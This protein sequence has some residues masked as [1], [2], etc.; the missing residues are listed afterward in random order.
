MELEEPEPP[1]RF[2][3]LIGKLSKKY[4]GQKEA[5]LIDEYDT[6]ILDEIAKPD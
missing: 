5:V 2:A 3:E 6:P 1:D 4:G